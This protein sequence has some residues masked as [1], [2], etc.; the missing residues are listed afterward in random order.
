MWGNLLSLFQLL[1]NMWGKLPESTK[2][3]IIEAIVESFEAVLKAFY[4]K[5]TDQEPKDKDND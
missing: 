5:S 2:N 3:K 1:F 4:K